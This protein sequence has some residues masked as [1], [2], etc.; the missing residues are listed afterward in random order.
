MVQSIG[1]PIIEKG[2]T[3]Q[4]EDTAPTKAGTSAS[5]KEPVVAESAP[6]TEKAG[7]K[8]SP[9]VLGESLPAVPAKLVTKIQ[10]GEYVD[11]AELLKDNMEIV[12]ERTPRKLLL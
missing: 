11:M 8:A 12:A 2:K 6:T 1:I 7:T 10:K 3:H 5:A 4:R 9:L